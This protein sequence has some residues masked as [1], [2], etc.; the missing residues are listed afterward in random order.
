MRRHSVGSGTVSQTRSAT[1]VD[2]AKFYRRSHDAVIR[3]YDEAGTV[4]ETRR[5]RI[6]GANDGKDPKMRQN[7]A[8][9]LLIGQFFFRRITL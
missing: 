8:S 9:A 7:L 6:P 2:Y 5:S 4:I 3:V 1:Q